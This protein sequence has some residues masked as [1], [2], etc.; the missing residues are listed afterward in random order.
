MIVGNKGDYMKRST[1]AIIGVLAISSLSWGAQ[2]VESSGKKM[3][4]D[5][6]LREGVKGQTAQMTTAERAALTKKAEGLSRKIGSGATS[7]TLEGLLKLNPNFE[8]TL[9]ALSQQKSAAKTKEEI[10][11]VEK[12]LEILLNAERLM[13]ANLSPSERMMVLNF[14]QRLHVADTDATGGFGKKAGTVAVSEIHTSVT[15]DGEGLGVA[16]LDGLQMAKTGIVNK[17]E[18]AERNALREASKDCQ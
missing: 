6:T 10:D 18:T 1:L 17:G 8:V 7:S 9:E 14:L 2:R 15:R 13:E 3:S 16:V 11:S 5:L 4:T 12:K